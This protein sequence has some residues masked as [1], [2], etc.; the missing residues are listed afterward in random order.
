MTTAA[1]T[2]PGVA[3]AERE[4]SELLALI[5]TDTEDHELQEA[6]REVLVTRYQSLVRGCVQRYR[7]SPEPV[8]DLMQAGYVGLL[9]AINNFDPVLGQNLAAYAQPCVSG[10]IKR[11]FRDKRWQIHVKRS[12][13]ELLLQVR[14]A[15]GE[16]AQELGRSPRDEE[17]ASHLGVTLDELRDAHRADMVFHSHSLDAPLYGQEDPASLSDLIGE[18]DPQVEHTLDMESVLTHWNDLPEREQRILTMRF[19]GNMTQAEIGD[20]L[21]ISQMHVSRLLARALRYL[22]DCLLGDEEAVAATQP[23]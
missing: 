8:E 23:G 17:M 21:G 3:L 19:Y 9:K 15:R 5:R 14:R 11:H 1:A 2:T 4:D 20:R 13:Q 16:L 7:E 6:V 18:E 10:E 22:R 12:A